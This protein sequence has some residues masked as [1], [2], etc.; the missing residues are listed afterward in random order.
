MNNNYSSAITYLLLAITLIGLGMFSFFGTTRSNFFL[1]EADEAYSVFVASHDFNG[2]I[3]ELKNDN[4][5]PL[6]YLLL[7]VWIRLFG[8][9]EFVVRS[10]S[11]IFYILTAF[12]MYRLGKMLGGYTLTGVLCSFLFLVS[13]LAIRHAQ[14]VRMY[15]L[16]GFLG[17]V[18]TFYCFRILL[19][20]SK[21]RWDFWFYG[22]SNV[23]GTFSHYWFFYLLLSHL[24]CAFCFLSKDLLKKW[25]I[26]LVASVIPFGLLWVPA[27][28]VQLKNGSSAWLTRP[29]LNVL[30]Q[31]LLDYY[32]GI[33]KALIVYGFCLLLIW[34]G[35]RK[36]S[37]N[38]PYR[39]RSV[40]VLGVIGAVLLIVPWVVS[41]FKPMYMV[42]RYTILTLLP[43][44]LLL[45][46]LVG[47]AGY[48]VLILVG[49]SV[50]L[51]VGLVDFITLKTRPLPYS[52]KM[53]ASYLASHADSNDI[54]LFTDLSRTPIE[55]HLRLLKSNR[56]FIPISFPL[57]MEN[58]LGWMDINNWLSKKELLANEAKR[59]AVH[60]DSLLDAPTRRIWLFYGWDPAING[61]LKA[62]LDERFQ[63]TSVH[64]LRGSSFNQVLVYK[65][66]TK[67][68][69]GDSLTASKALQAKAH[70]E[71]GLRLYDSQQD[72]LALKEFNAAIQANPRY[73]EAWG[74]LGLLY[75][76]RSGELDKAK[77]ALTRAVALD[78]LNASY[79]T[80][81]GNAHFGLDEK[82]DALASWQKALALRPDD[83]VLKSNIAA[84]QREI[85]K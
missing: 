73:A 8:I 40:F 58:H 44:A 25:L 85:L 63:L 51:A 38:M 5:A 67:P 46:Y 33:P 2:I 41:Q 3:G 43:F 29:G 62:K 75:A 60:F 30:V 78:S 79:W 26:V 59:L 71:Q 37:L 69:G 81:L 64:D 7:A 19:K 50:L 35:W 21:S 28:L 77:E 72:S 1:D 56:K 48:R 18:S 14:N 34:L 11:G 10:L 23:L 76:T 31:T 80:N 9:S 55:Y 24:I 82:K 17:A 6:H 12:F 4:S 32:G 65:K 66:Q 13:P 83:P 47:K 45:G 70:Y 49:C 39:G 22:L 61:I 84:L 27:F 42:G 53:T 57:E 74:Q 68:E 54:L 16:L 20:Q 36:K 52:N 15:S